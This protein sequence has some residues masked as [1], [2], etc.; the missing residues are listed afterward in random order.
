MAEES[1]QLAL[2]T[3]KVNEFVPS[4]TVVI[5]RGLEVDVPLTAA[6]NLLL[7]QVRVAHLRQMADKKIIKLMD[8]DEA[9]DPLKA[10]DLKDIVDAFARLEDMARFA[11]AP[12]LNELEGGEK[13]KHAAAEV[14]RAMAEGFAM[15]G[16]KAVATA[17]ED[18]MK[19]ILELGKPKKGKIVEAMV[20][21]EVA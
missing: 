4:L 3:R 19:A 15:A 13:A 6:D 16:H 20:D 17:K 18:K 8:D 14:A 7:S 1:K 10:K 12:V 21:E 5:R 11:Y 9:E 2:P